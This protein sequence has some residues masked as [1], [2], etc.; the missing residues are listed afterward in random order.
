MTGLNVINTLYNTSPIVIH[1]HGSHDHKPNWLPIRDA[2]FASPPGQIDADEMVTV[3][4]CNN[5]HASMGLLER[6]LEHLGVPYKVF[7][8]GIH[9]W[10]N[11]YH[12]PRILYEALAT[13]T[14]P[15]VLYADSRDAILLGAPGIAVRTFQRHFTCKMLFGGDRI[16]WPPIHTF[17]KYEEALARPH[18]TAFP[19]LNGGAWMGE[20]EFSRDLF[21]MAIDTPPE[22]KAPE[23]EQG[24][25]KKIFPA[26][27]GDVAIDYHCRII[28]NIGFVTAP[29][30][31]IRLHKLQNPQHL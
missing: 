4:T 14:T 3:I 7:G 11:S 19:F 20:T 8:R 22:E 9:P 13:I 16:N 27:G 17:Q 30:F 12:K 25:L 23:S 26:F 10:I 1:A 29:I 28:Q 15:Y 6:S 18:H 31:D 24:I 5:G 2:F 21:K